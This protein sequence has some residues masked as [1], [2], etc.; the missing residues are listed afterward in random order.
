MILLTLPLLCASVLAVVI[1]PLLAPMTP[2][3]SR[4]AAIALLLSLAVATLALL[5][6]LS[7]QAIVALPLIGS[8]LHSWLHLDGVHVV[9]GSSVGVIASLL[10]S[11]VV[12]KLIQMLVAQRK[13]WGLH[14][15]GVVTL[16]DPRRF[17]YAIP[18]RR[19]GIVISD[20]LI[21][22][23]S[24]AE[25]DAVLRH[26]QAHIDGRHDLWLL[27]ARACVVLNPI[28]IPVKR[29]LEFALERIADAAAERD[30]GDTHTVVS[31]LSKAALGHWNPTGSLGITSSAVSARVRWLRSGTNHTH[32]MH[33]TVVLT[34][35]LAVAGLSVL[36]GHHIIAAIQAVC[37]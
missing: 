6:H 14:P 24:P 15:G 31:A 27:V 26:E 29:Q 4:R 23:L 1:A 32:P 8:R 37:A 2:V 25:L 22:S 36:Q 19:P 10:S 3:A 33:L 30:C 5:L 11:V 17:A 13:L 20:G 7:M 16:P 18:G 21:S 28:L 35:C 9:R 34:G 12:V